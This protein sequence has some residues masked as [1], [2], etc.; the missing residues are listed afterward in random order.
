MKVENEKFKLILFLIY[1]IVFEAMVLG[2]FGYV[3]FFMNYSMWLL[4]PMILLSGSQLKPK[5]FGL[6]Y[7]ID[8]YSNTQ[9]N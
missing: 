2:G 8:T 7:K 5:H 6:N 1:T 3:I 4:I 9:A